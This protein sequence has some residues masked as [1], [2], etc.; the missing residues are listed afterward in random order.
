M[1]FRRLMNLQPQAVP[2]RLLAM[3]W[4]GARLRRDAD[5]AGFV[6]ATIDRD[7]LELGARLGEVGPGEVE[8][9]SGILRPEAGE[10]VPELAD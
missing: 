8:G 3:M 5:V 4:T 6:W 2:F 7:V 10:V 9:R 1:A